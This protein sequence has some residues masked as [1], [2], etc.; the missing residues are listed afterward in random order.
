MGR[1]AGRIAILAIAIAI[2]SMGGLAWAERTPDPVRLP[3]GIRTPARPETV[4]VVEGDHLWKISER[5]L[6]KMTGGSP[7]DT[8]ITPY[9]REVVKLN[10]DNLRSG[11]P[12][13]IYPGEVIALP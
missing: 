8:E 9:W 6:G 13:L 2:A 12:D 7:V 5:R 11:D 3:V 1:W 10:R 4:T